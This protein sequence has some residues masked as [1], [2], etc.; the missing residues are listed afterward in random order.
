M[1]HFIRRLRG[2]QPDIIVGQPTFGYPQVRAENDVINASWR[3]D[4]GSNNLAD[5]VGLMVYEGSMSLDYVKN[6]AQGT[7]QWE[8]FPIHVN[9]PYESIVVGCKGSASSDDVAR[10]ATECMTKGL[11]GIMVWFASVRGGFVYATSWD[12]SGSKESQDALLAA[13]ELFNS[14]Q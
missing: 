4:G 2:L 13:M 5:S 9:V 11:Q 10:L 7:Q 12:A 3:P 8:G 14:D 6:Y 1:V